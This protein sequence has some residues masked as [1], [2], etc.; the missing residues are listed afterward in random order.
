M[1]KTFKHAID[2]LIWAFKNERNLKIHTVAAVFVFG[3]GLYLDIK[4]QYWIA[5]FLCVG[6][7]ISAELIN[8]AI[9]KTLDLLHPQISDKVKIIK[10]ISAGAVLVLSIVAV[11]VGC[12]VF[13]KYLWG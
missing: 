11:V 10:D 13:G 4:T 5:L 12:L 9:E 7:V 1:I 8:T 3:L 2:G 6:V